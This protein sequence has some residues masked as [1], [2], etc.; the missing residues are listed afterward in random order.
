ML[1]NVTSKFSVKTNN[2][3]LLTICKSIAIYLA[4]FIVG[5]N[6]IP[7]DYN[8]YC[9]VTVVALNI[10]SL[11]ISNKYRGIISIKCPLF[12]DICV[13]LIAALV[14]QSVMWHWPSSGN[15]NYYLTYNIGGKLFYLIIMFILVPISEEIYFR[16]LIFPVISNS[17]GFAVGANL[18]IMLFI[19]YHM[20]ASGFIAWFL[21]GWVCTWLMRR[22]GTIV[23]SIIAH[24]TYNVIWLIHALI[25]S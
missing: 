24:V 25:N 1:T 6:S 7:D 23:T 19:L 17:F 2:A 5:I 12:K 9:I 14:I 11:T 22:T 18:S 13:A 21:L 4:I 20:T 10:S 3:C 15:V 16:G 8:A